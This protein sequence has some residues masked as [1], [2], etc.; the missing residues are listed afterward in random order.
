MSNDKRIRVG[1]LMGSTSDWPTVQHAALMLDELGVGHEARVLS[2]HRSPHAAA[3]YAESA[4][5]RGLQVIICA[6]GGAAHL[7]GVIA[8]HTHLPVLGIPMMGWATDGLDSL[9]S[10]VQ[11]P[12]GIPVGTL[13]VGKAGAKNAGL[14]AVAIMSLSDE[15]LR[16]RY[17]AFRK[18][19]T[20]TVLATKLPPAGSV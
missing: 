10:T 2:A 16:E 3:E 19:Q 17:L 5:G 12:A 14:L 7:A 9:L 4:A 20:E 1:I 13:A 11:M 6:A 18:A 15:A 8:A